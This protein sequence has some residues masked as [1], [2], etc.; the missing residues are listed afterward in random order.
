MLL[1]I[2][3]QSFLVTLCKI[4]VHFLFMILGTSLQDSLI[5]EMSMITMRWKIKY[6]RVKIQMKRRRVQQTCKTISLKQLRVWFINGNDEM[7]FKLLLKS[8]FRQILK[9]F[10]LFVSVYSIYNTSI[11]PSYQFSFLIGTNW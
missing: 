7:V 5:V 4:C 1:N 8:F 3:R 9:K 11:A 2:I 6:F 10:L